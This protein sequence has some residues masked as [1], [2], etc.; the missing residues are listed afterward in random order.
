[1]QSPIVTI[2]KITGA[3]IL[4]SPISLE[5]YPRAIRAHARR[6][7][8][9]SRKIDA[10][11][12]RR[13][14]RRNQRSLFRAVDERRSRAPVYQRTKLPISNFEITTRVFPRGAH[15]LVGRDGNLA[16]RRYNGV[17]P[18]T[19]FRQIE[20]PRRRNG[21]LYV[22]RR[23]ARLKLRPFFPSSIGPV[24]AWKEDERSP[25][26]PRVSAPAGADI[27]ASAP[28]QFRGEPIY[29]ERIAVTG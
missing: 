17:R 18:A 20:F 9:I 28:T 29:A 27:R 19:R 11:V 12:Q 22:P 15:R 4:Y 6:R 21:R 3:T 13:A 14:N 2:L 7:R 25:I 5:R 10:S 26:S 24:I 8:R 23:K 16:G 1:M